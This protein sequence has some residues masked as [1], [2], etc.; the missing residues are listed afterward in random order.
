MRA[1]NLMPADARSGRPGTGIGVYL[2][3]GG[4]AMLAAFA[5]LWA[6]ADR[7]IGDRTAALQRVAAQTRA[8]EARADAAAPYGAFAKLAKDRVATV[9]SLSTTRFDWAHSLGEIS[10]VLPADVWLTSMDGASGSSDAAPTT[11]TSAAPAPTFSL[12]GCTATQRKVALLLA[13]LHAVDGVRKVDLKTSAK[14]DGDATNAVC[15]ASKASNPTFE[16]MIS[17]AV[18]GGAKDTL[19]A[20][21]QVVAPVAAA[22][23]P[24]GTNAA[25]ATPAAP[26]PPAAPSS[27]VSQLR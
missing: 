12:A 25:P 24:S 10:R 20:A 5:L 2:L 26:A 7:R 21:G 15:P 13:R 23:A 4:L 9:T 22:P 8:A 3:L 18:P 27:E 17:F 14:P 16:I 19:D 6:L 1:V 11:T